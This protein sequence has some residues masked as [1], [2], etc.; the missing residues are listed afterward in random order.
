MNSC[1]LITFISSLACAI[2]KCCDPDEL[3]LLAAVFTQLGDT[4]TTMVIQREFC[5][6]QKEKSACNS[7]SK[8]ASPSK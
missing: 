1:E 5:E 2:A 7:S 6:N 3:A 8:I 4:L